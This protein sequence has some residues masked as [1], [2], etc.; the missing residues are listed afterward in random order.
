MPLGMINKRDTK[1]KG[2][3]MM[4]GQPLARVVEEARPQLRD[5]IRRDRVVALE[6][7]RQSL[8]RKKTHA[9]PRRARRKNVAYPGICR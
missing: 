8:R 7:S 4:Y 5:G 9:E 3:P 1:P 2:R 6:T